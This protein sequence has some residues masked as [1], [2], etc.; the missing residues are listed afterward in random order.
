MLLCYTGKTR[1]SDPI[2][3]GQIKRYISQKSDT[4]AAMARLKEIARLQK[5]ALL[6]KKIREFGDLLHEAWE[7]KKKMAEVSTP[8]ID[9]LY[10][11][12]R[13]AGALGGKISGAGQGGYMF[14]LCNEGKK[15]YVA[16]E[17]ER[18]GAKA[19]DFE[20]EHNG[21]QTWRK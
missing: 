10:L 9:N 5:N 16:E 1:H 11:V 8:F 4:I 6:R 3:A 12:A 18:L 14:F 7:E 15:Y 19:V 20:F 21:L 13:K 17:L 2:I